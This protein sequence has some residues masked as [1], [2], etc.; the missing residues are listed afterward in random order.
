[1][2]EKRHMILQPHEVF[3]AEYLAQ[4]VQSR[5]LLQ[6]RGLMSRYLNHPFVTKAERRLIESELDL[7]A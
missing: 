1:M 4:A 7:A 5:D 2:K 6:L 3:E